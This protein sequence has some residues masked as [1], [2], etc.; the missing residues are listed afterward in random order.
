MTSGVASFSPIARVPRIHSIGVASPCSATISAAHSL[1]GAKGSS[2]ISL[3]AM[4]GMYSSRSDEAA[5][6]PRLG[7][8]AEP[9]E[10]E[11]VL[12]EDRVDEPGDD[13]RSY[14]MIPG[15]APLA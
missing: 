8:A 6:Y 14:P 4:T 15:K 12:G 9:E 5:D 11:F 13:S 7:L 10:D 1:T 2:L 3:P